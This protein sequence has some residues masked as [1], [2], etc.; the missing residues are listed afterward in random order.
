MAIVAISATAELLF[1]YFV[2]FF[3]TLSVLFG[4]TRHCTL[5]IYPSAFGRMKIVFSYRIR[6]VSHCIVL[7]TRFFGQRLVR[8]A[9][10]Y[11]EWGLGPPV[12]TP[13]R[14]R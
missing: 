5:S 2:V 10:F 14:R 7:L 6:I 3:I 11:L 1:V 8:M 4:S 13:L 9:N 12:G